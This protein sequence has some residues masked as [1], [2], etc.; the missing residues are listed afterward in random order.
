[1]T[2]RSRPAFS[3]AP[4]AICAGDGVDRRITSPISRSIAQTFPGSL[5][6]APISAYSMGSYFSQSP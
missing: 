2:D 6:K 1:M 4:R 3:S 5:M